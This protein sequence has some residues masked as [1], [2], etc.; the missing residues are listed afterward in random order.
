MTKIQ[1]MKDY[2]TIQLPNKVVKLKGHQDQDG[3]RVFSESIES[4]PTISQKERE[5]IKG[6]LSDDPNTIVD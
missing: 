4:H 3:F 1:E 6:I 5:I 2:I